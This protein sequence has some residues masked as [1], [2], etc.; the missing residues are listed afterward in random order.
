MK[1]LPFVFWQ[2]PSEGE[3][4]LRLLKPRNNDTKG[5]Y[6]DK[7]WIRNFKNPVDSKVLECC[8]LAGP[9]DEAILVNTSKGILSLKRDVYLQLKALAESWAEAERQLSSQR[10]KARAFKLNKMKYHDHY[11]R[12]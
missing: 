2:P 5:Y 6:F 8:E 10:K 3:L 1:D 12:Q 7:Y 4:K 9:S 11:S